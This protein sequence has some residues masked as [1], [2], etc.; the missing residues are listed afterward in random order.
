M[1]EAVW[2]KIVD[3]YV[4]EI[5]ALG[6]KAEQGELVGDLVRKKVRKCL[7]EMHASGAEPEDIRAI[8][9]SLE[10]QARA[11]CPVSEPRL[12]QLLTAARAH[13]EFLLFIEENRK[14]CARSDGKG[15]DLGPFH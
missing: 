12:F 13:A 5:R 9:G 7:I 10:I 14:S 2:E 1:L 4:Q 15:E 3:R 11:P 8:F 6:N